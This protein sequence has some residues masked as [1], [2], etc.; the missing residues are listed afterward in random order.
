LRLK[1]KLDY[2]AE[3]SFRCV[4]CG[5]CCG[6]TKEKVRH[7]LLLTP[8]AKQVSK[9]TLQPTSR[10]AVKIEGREPYRYEM[11]K[12]KE[13]K[14]VFLE[15]NYCTIYSIRPLIC[16]FYP[17]ELNSYGGKYSFR[18][19]EECPGI[20]KGRVMGE[21]SFRKMLR[22]ARAKHKQ[23]ADSNGKMI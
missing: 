12:N 3:V 23:A 19:S 18:F 6:D 14:C 5:I 7:V 8:E 9:A 22:L 13:G 2:P 21:E 17:F 10:F 11:R 20:G 16:R 1:V 4:K 15:N